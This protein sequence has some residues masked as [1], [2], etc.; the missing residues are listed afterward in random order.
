MKKLV[1]LI[2]AALSVTAAAQ[3]PSSE[4]ADQDD[5]IKS[6]TGR[7]LQGLRNGQG[8][9]AGRVAELNG[10]PGPRHV[11]ELANELELSDGQIE[12]TQLAFAEMRSAA[13]AAGAE[14]I[15]AERS[16][17][18]RFAAHDVDPE[19]VA[20]TIGEIG[21][22][23]AGLR[24]IHIEAHMKMRE[25]LTDAQIEA[26]GLLR[27]EAHGEMRGQGQRHG[28]GHGNRQHR[29]QAGEN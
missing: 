12:Q 18:A 25:I 27:G 2:L 11:L 4:S 29:P 26:Y 17:D 16:L 28:Q 13:M 5:S 3:E 21:A 23:R 15:E 24:Y 10:Y 8:M 19:S 6:L 22:M 9:G 20:A 7:D 14:I 1:I